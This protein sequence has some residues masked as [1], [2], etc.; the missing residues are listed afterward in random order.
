MKKAIFFYETI[1]KKVTNV[2][3]VFAG[4]ILFVPAL[5]IFY[6]VVMRGM[7]NA[8]TEWSIELSVYC[9]LVAGFLGMPVTYGA[10]KHIKVDIFTSKL[11]PKNYCF[12]EILASTIGAIFCLVFFV[13]AVNMASL[14]YEIDRR[15]PDTLRVPLWIPQLSM[16]IG[17]GML[18]LHFLGTIFV[19]ITKL[20][21]GEFSKEVA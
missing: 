13:E 6:E 12:L 16:P 2:M 11:S 20:T 10:G 15:S 4:V 5:M 7:F 14:S 3:G 18:F 21:S 19:D 8:P 17:I 1:L 9:V